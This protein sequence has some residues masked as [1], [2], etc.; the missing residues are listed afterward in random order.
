[1]P[2]MKLDYEDGSFKVVHTQVAR[3]GIPIY[4]YETV[5]SD[6]WFIYE[7][8]RESYTNEWIYVYVRYGKKKEFG[9]GVHTFK[10]NNSTYELSFWKLVNI[11]P[12]TKEFYHTHKIIKNEPRKPTYRKLRDSQKSKVYK[13]ESF[14][15]IRQELNDEEV[16]E[17][18]LSILV[19]DVWAEF[20]KH[21]I[22]DKDQDVPLNL[23]PRAKRVA[24]GGVNGLTLPDWAKNKGII[25]HELAHVVIQRMFNY[26]IK[27]DRNIQ[28]HGKEYCFVY[29][30][31]LGHFM[32]DAMFRLILRFDDWNV[33]YL[34]EFEYTGMSLDDVREKVLETAL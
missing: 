13:A 19:S 16:E 30:Y 2:Y 4:H 27:R 11:S 15:K 25:I 32:P 12:C 8:E 18:V 21:F 28:S 5:G 17:F 33:K 1:M 23:N 9:G 20:N 34:T 10:F 7:P 31:L 26:S 29:L 14:L 22:Y 3:T 6:D 24:T